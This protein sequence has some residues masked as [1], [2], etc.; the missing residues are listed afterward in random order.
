MLLTTERLLLRE[1][2]SCPLQ[3]LV[4]LYSLDRSGMLAP[5]PLWSDLARHKFGSVIAAGIPLLGAFNLCFNPR[6]LPGPRA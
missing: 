1:F 2:I 4:H 3:L 6:L 5:L